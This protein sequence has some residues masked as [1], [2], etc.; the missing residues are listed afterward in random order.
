M[1]SGW[2]GASAG[3]TPR[4]V[5]LAPPR[6]LHKPAV[7][8]RFGTARRFFA[9][10]RPY[11]GRLLLSLLLVAVSSAIPSAIIFL[12]QSVLNDLLIRKEAGLLAMLPLGVVGLFGLNGLV[13]VARTLL[14]RGV[15]WEVVTRIRDELYQH[16]LR[17][18]IDWHQSFHSGERVSRL[19]ADVNNLQYAT[20][21]LVIALQK[22]LTL[23][24]LIVTAFVMNPKLAAAA[25]IALPLV[26]IPI[27]RFGKWVRGS[28]K[29]AQDATAAL[30]A[31]AQETLAG[32]RVVQ[33]SDGA[34]ERAAAF[35]TLN[36]KHHDAQL[37]VLTAQ[38][39]PGPIVEFIA[40]IGV[41]LVIWLG[42]RDVLAGEL[43][44]GSLVA[45]LLALM[46]MNEPLKGLAQMSNL[47][48][49]SLASAETV[50]ALLD[51]PS[52]LTDAGTRLAAPPKLIRLEGVGFTYGE[53]PPVLSDVSFE[54]KA[55]ERI[56][57]VGTSGSGKTTLLNLLTRL[58][59][60][61]VGRITW[62]GGD[63]RELG[64]K[65]LRAQIA[66]V[67]QEPFLFDD[68][69]VANIRFGCPG[70]SDSEVEAAARAANAWEF[71]VALPTPRAAPEGALPAGFYT[72]IDELGMRLSGGQR[73]RICIARAV[74]RGASVL[75]LDEATSNLDAESEAA[76]AA[77][78]DRLMKG[79]TTFLVAHRLSTVRDADRIVVVADG[80]IVE[81][82][83]HAELIAQDGVYSRLVARQESAAS[84]QPSAA[85]PG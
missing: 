57:V 43:E 69:I 85:V 78:L 45:F 18:D 7:P 41:A 83:Q 8:D 52:A 58:R 9:Y 63:L 32:I 31:S 4:P 55:G 16:L 27:D 47:I 40:A 25:L 76:V 19:I 59:D 66:V 17:L 3:D 33:I 15:S 14:V 29:D 81:M 62:D 35:S 46:M 2:P 44:A 51:T 28:S 26:A 80:R 53:G 23:L 75:V 56:A 48:Q 61:T 21:G 84:P 30:S 39:L 73:Q 71:I 37:Q 64:Q 42:G 82:G 50:F 65:G 79:R 74:L 1:G 20:A 49:R 11:V 38:L 10:F 54:V 22:P 68:T 72:R 12:L 5:S 60:P 70:A 34:E 6:S 67:T 24:G 36:R 77:A 13:N